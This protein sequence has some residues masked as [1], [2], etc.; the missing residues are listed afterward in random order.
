MNYKPSHHVCNPALFGAIGRVVV[1][2]A[3]GVKMGDYGDWGTNSP[4]GVVSRQ[5][6]V[7]A[8]T[9]VIFLCITK[10]RRW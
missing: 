2:R 4:D 5:Q 7:G 1:E 6:I 3:L 9:S 10:S 8:S